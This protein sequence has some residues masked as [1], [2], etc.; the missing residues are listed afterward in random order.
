VNINADLVKST[1]IRGGMSEAQSIAMIKD[2]FSS[3]YRE[4]YE[5]GYDSG[6]SSCD[7]QSN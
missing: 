1:L 2:M 5:E 6:Y 7:I 3:G 4:G